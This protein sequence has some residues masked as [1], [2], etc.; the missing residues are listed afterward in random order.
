MVDVM[1]M[2]SNWMAA[3]KQ[4]AVEANKPKP[5]D[6]S[7]PNSTALQDEATK[8]TAM[9]KWL[10]DRQRAAQDAKAKAGK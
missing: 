2:F 6:K 8:N 7:D 5:G 4:K 10:L 1:G 3:Q 9:F